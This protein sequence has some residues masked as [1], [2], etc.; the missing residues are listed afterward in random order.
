MKRATPEALC[1]CCALGACLAISA[2]TAAPPTAIEPSAPAATKAWTRLAQRGHGAEAVFALCR[3][4]ACPHPTPK[5]LNTAPRVVTPAEPD[6]A[7]VAPVPLIESMGPGEQVE[8][9][10]H[11][12]VPETEE[13]PDAI[14][15]PAA[16]QHGNSIQTEN[17]NTHLPG[18]W[19]HPAIEPTEPH[20]PIDTRPFLPGDS[21]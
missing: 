8:T 19:P 3:G 4:D 21:S 13:P 10:T 15:P 6:P 1:R 7:A 9:Q 16:P 14:A 18:P 5:T 17:E 20:H 11:Q 12:A 2:C